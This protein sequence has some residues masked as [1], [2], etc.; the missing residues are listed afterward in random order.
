MSDGA[1]SI[2]QRI[3]Y[4]ILSKIRGLLQDVAAF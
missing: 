1:L 4:P 2:F 3:S